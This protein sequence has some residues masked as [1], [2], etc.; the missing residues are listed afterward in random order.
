MIGMFLFDFVC[1]LPPLPPLDPP[2]Q[3]LVYPSDA[4]VSGKDLTYCGWDAWGNKMKCECTPQ[5]RGELD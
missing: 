1:P 4:D 3:Q 2:H 5:E